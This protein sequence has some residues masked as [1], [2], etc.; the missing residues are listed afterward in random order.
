MGGNLYKDVLFAFVFILLVMLTT[1][2]AFLSDP[3][4]EAKADPPGTLAMA[5]T[6]PEGNTDIDLWSFGP[7]EIAPVGY[8][9]LSGSLFNLL[10]D[11]LG[12]MPDALG[13]NFE[14]A[15][16]RGIVPGEY[17]FTAHC[18]RCPVLPQTV[19]AE[20]TITDQKGQKK[21][22][23]LV[24][25]SITL[26]RQGEEKTIIRFKLDAEGNLVPNSMNQIPRKLRSPT[27]Q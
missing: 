20:V 24:T 27:A 12:N 25:T 23:P 3:T 17:V 22:H 10:R 13:L 18:F 6:W 5:I 2:L 9:N 21:T 26:T 16:T 8:S 11:D 7:Q 15:Y 19:K 4:E 1:L 14:H